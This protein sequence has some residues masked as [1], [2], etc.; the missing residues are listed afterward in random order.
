MDISRKRRRFWIHY[1]P[2]Y[3]SPKRDWFSRKSVTAA[4]GTRCSPSPQFLWLT[5]K[6]ITTFSGFIKARERT[7]DRGRKR[8]R[9]RGRKT[10]EKLGKNWEKRRSRTGGKKAKPAKGER[11]KT[12][13][14]ER[15]TQTGRKKGRG[16]ARTRTEQKKIYTEKRRRKAEEQ[17]LPSFLQTKKDPE[18]VKTNSQKWA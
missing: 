15:K 18:S 5:P 17:P 4:R 2:P 8:N 10:E 11:Q 3:S 1:S 16:R 12:Q 7:N 13:G 9:N 6:I 14:T